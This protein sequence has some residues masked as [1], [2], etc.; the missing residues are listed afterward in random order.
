MSGYW[1]AYGKI[2]EYYN[3]LSLS[4]ELHLDHED[5]VVIHVTEYFISNL[6]YKIYQ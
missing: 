5:S 4:V 1:L 6:E 3:V 2:I